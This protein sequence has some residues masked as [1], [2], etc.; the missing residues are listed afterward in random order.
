VVGVTLALP[1]TRFVNVGRSD[2]TEVMMLAVRDDA[3]GRGIAHAL[4]E[5]CERRSHGEGVAGVVRGPH[6]GGVPRACPAGPT[7]RP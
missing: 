5:A 6:L 2:Q 4:M 3:R 7:G 1:G